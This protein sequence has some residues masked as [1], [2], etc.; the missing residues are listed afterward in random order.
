MLYFIIQNS[1]LQYCSKRKE[2]CRKKPKELKNFF[3]KSRVNKTRKTIGV[4]TPEIGVY[5]STS[6]TLSS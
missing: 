3:F 6:L 1:L 2:N 4:G 5:N